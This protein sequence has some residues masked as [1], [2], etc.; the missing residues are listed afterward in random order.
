MNTAT[1]TIA[2]DRFQSAI[3]SLYIKRPR[4]INFILIM[5]LLFSAFSVIYL[6]D[7]NRRLFIH[8]QALQTAHDRLYEDWG[9][10]LLEQSTWS[11]QSRVKKIAQR[12]LGMDTPSSKEMVV[13]R[14]H[15]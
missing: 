15:K 7:V 11:S 6:K 9:K 3:P 10:L 2:Q 1:R 5:A 8:Y 13:L 12:R 4:L 14:L